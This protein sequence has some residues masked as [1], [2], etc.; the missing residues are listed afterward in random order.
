MIQPALPLDK[1]APVSGQDCA[2][3]LALGRIRGVGGVS[4]KKITARFADP[5]A[6][7]C[8]SVAELGEIEGVARDFYQKSANFTDRAENENEIQ[9]AR[10]AG[11]KMI[12]FSAAAYPARLRAIVDPP[13]L[14]YVNGEIRENDERAVAIVGSRSASDYGR[15]VARDLARGLVSFCFSVVSGVARRIDGMAA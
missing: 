7:F 14:L 11:I 15:R 4:L 1:G 6:G 9:R 3:W 10:A 13:A 12:P 5:A 2:P 8:A